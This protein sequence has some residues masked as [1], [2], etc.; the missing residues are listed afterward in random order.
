MK[1][2]FIRKITQGQ[3]L[4]L[5][6]RVRRLI[7]ATVANEWKGTGE[8]EDQDDIEAELAEATTSYEKYLAK[9]VDGPKVPK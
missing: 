1:Q 5:D 3:A 2:K 7:S 8:Y 4:A 9:L 6:S